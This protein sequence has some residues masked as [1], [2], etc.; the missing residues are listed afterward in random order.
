VIIT[1][2]PVDN[3][4]S[5]APFIILFAL[6]SALL[7]VV[8]DYLWNNELAYAVSLF[9]AILIYVVAMEYIFFTDKPNG[10]KKNVSV[11]MAIITTTIFV[12]TLANDEASSSVIRFILEAISGFLIIIFAP[13]VFIIHRAKNN[14]K[15]QH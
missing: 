4:S 11:L 2:I 10:S 7:L 15:I 3:E 8:N 1:T 14:F 6:L 13:L 5:I 12:M 9:F